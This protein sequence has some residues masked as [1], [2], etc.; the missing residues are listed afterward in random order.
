[1][2]DITQECLKHSCRQHIQ[3]S[4]FFKITTVG[5]G[6]KIEEL[7]NGEGYMCTGYTCIRN[8]MRRKKLSAGE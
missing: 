1:M 3:K 6:Y 4:M 2:G 8:P 5:V 7:A